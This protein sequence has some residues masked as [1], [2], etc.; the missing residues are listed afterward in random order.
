MSSAISRTRRRRSSRVSGVRSSASC[1]LTARSTCSDR[2]SEVSL[3]N[4]RG[5]IFAIT[6]WWIDVFS[7]A[8]GSAAAVT[9]WRRAPLPFGSASGVSSPPPGAPEAG[10][11]RSWRPTLAPSERRDQAPL[12]RLARR[13]GEQLLAHLAQRAR[14][15][16][17]GLGQY[18]GLAAVD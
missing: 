7:C 1:S 8:Y 18:H 12:R 6:E 15:R 9:T 13:S 10:L 3:P 11:S 2:S 14:E 17:A 5:P 4:R 16:R